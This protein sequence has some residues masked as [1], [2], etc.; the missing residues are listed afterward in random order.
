MKSIAQIIHYSNNIIDFIVDTT[1]ESKELV[2]QVI[3]FINNNKLIH[4]SAY[5]YKDNVYRILCAYTLYESIF[6]SNI[7]QS[8]FITEKNI[9]QNNTIKLI[10]EYGHDY[11]PLMYSIYKIEFDNNSKI[12]FLKNDCIS[13]RGYSLNTAILLDIP[14]HDENI[15]ET[16]IYSTIHCNGKINCPKF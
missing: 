5:R 4:I 11:M 8:A 12:L 14:V 6:R 15:L 2:E 10:A 9:R 7:V 16:I 1:N 3:N 13:T